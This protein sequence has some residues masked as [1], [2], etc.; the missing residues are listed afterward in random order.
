MAEME[1]KVLEEDSNYVLDE[2]VEVKTYEYEKLLNLEANRQLN[3]KAKKMIKL[4]LFEQTIEK[5]IDFGKLSKVTYKKPFKGVFDLYISDEGQLLYI[6]EKTESEVGRAY[7]YDVI[8]VEKTTDEE[9]QQ[10]LSASAHEKE[11]L[12][13]FAY[14]FSWIA[15]FAATIIYLT[16]NVF[17]LI[18]GMNFSDLLA[19]YSNALTFLGMLAALVTISSI[20]YRKF[21]TR[22]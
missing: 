19:F 4:G 14:C 20:S 2:S 11:G 15:F 3:V 21:T 7:E 12:I 18:K 9:Y 16:M 6:H 10:I 1:T 22:K 8:A 13:K 5:E 17:Y